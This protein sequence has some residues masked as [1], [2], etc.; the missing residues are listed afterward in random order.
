MGLPGAEITTHQL[1]AYFSFLCAI[2]ESSG[3]PV[4]I[5]AN[6]VKLI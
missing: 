2:S 6:V 3:V 5:K 4:V 1:E